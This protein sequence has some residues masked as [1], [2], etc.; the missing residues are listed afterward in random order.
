MAKFESPDRVVIALGG[1]ALGDTLWITD[2][3]GWDGVGSFREAYNEIP[4]VFNLTTLSTFI[5]TVKD[6]LS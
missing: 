6:E 4:Y 3:K 5:E 2:G 1:N